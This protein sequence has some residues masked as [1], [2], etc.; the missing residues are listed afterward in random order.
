MDNQQECHGN[1]T[2]IGIIAAKA[3][4]TAQTAQI[5]Y[6]AGERQVQEKTLTSSEGL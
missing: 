1:K 4:K 5:T 3:K 6:L 2:H